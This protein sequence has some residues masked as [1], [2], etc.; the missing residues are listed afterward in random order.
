MP[1]PQMYYLDAASL[2]A[3]TSIF[4]DPQLTV[5]APD[6][7]YSDT[8]VTREMALGVLLPAQECLS[9]SDACG[10]PI[11]SGEGVGVFQIDT[12]T[13]TA[14]GAIRVYFNPLSKPNGIK[15]VYNGQVYN[16]LSSPL[17]GVHQSTNPLNY[18]FVGETADD[19]G[20]SGTTY[21]ALPVFEYKPGIGFELQPTTQG[22]TVNA[23]DVSLSAGPS[24]SSMLMVIPKTAAT[25]SIVNLYIA[26]PCDD[27]TFSITISC[28][29]PLM[30]FQSSLPVA[31]CEE[32]C[33]ASVN[34]Q[35]YVATLS[36]G[37]TVGIY[38]YVFY[39]GFGQTPLPD[40][41]YGVW[42]DEVHYCMQVINGV[43]VAL[44]ICGGCIGFWLTN[45]TDEPGVN[46]I[47]VSYVDCDG[48]PVITSPVGL[49][50]SIC[51]NT[52]PAGFAA[53]T[54]EWADM[55]IPQPT[56]GD[57][58]VTINGCP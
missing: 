30:P 13:G 24:V 44:D 55:H 1:I 22:L 45:T 49:G 21:P 9:C 42:I 47:R 52:T 54:F 32:A 27:D 53:M 25:P 17:D 34:Q 28:P 38:D 48:V 18:T 50:A 58:T 8:L 7:F 3:A 5:I 6:G 19:C 15:A 20:I 10:N 29:E 33:A 23:G 26:S 2:S 56:I 57:F 12:N 11:T 40:G 46:A 41:Y 4:I 35:Y 14:T 43:I 51:V 16:K 31:N 36:G 37:T 39:D